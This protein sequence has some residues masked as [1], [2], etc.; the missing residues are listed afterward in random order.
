V[1]QFYL[2]EM[3]FSLAVTF[4]IITTVNKEG[5]HSIK[6]AGRMLSYFSFLREDICRT[7][8]RNYV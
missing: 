3:V 7:L 5:G 8:T 6:A 4:I 1:S 2:L